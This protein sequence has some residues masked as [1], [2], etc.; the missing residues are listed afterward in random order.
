[1]LC[2][3]NIDPDV[4]ISPNKELGMQNISGIRKNYTREVFDIREDFKNY[5]NSAAGSVPWQLNYVRRG[6]LQVDND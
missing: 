3:D 4:D 1:M 5:F 6:R 2:T